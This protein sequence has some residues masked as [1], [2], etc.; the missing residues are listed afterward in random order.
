MNHRTGLQVAVEQDLIVLVQ[1]AE[2]HGADMEI[3][4][5]VR[6]VLFGVESHGVSSFLVTFPT[7]SIP[8]GYAEEG[9]SISINRLQ[10]TPSSVRCA[11]ASRR[12]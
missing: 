1:D 7:S 12:G 6:F 11:P 5:T 8:P 4:A 9:A 3:D 2:I 10:P